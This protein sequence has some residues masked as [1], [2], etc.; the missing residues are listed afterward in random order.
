MTYES[1]SQTQTQYQASVSKRAR[2][3]GRAPHLLSADEISAWVTGRIEAGLSPRTTNGEVSAL[4]LFFTDTMGQPD[5]VEGLHNRR[6]PDRLPRT[7]PE[8]DVERLITGVN[9]PCYRTAILTAYGAG[10]RISEVVTLQVSDIKSAEG[11]LRLGNGKGGHERMASLRPGPRGAPALLAHH[12]AASGQLAVPS[13]EPGSADHHQQIAP[14]LQRGTKPNVVQDTRGHKS[15]ET[16]RVYVP[17]PPVSCSA[18]ST[19]RRLPSPAPS[20]RW[21]L[22]CPSCRPARRWH[23]ECEGLHRAVPDTGARRHRVS[24]HG[25]RPRT[26]CLEV[27][28]QPPLSGLPGRRGTQV[29]GEAA[30]LHPA[31]AVLP[32]RLHA[33]ASGRPDR[34]AEPQGCLRYPVPEGGRDAAHD[35]C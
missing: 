30:G 10:L 4:R 32:H 1:N 14:G 17:A 28:R 34:D 25:L 5:K 26:R 35:Q 19:I 21:A 8:A 13:Q 6:I 33:A 11:L 7:M 2:H 22:P 20:E 12:R 3:Y 27:L 24:L 16:T 31:G 9:D 18:S 15:P 29:G 23:A